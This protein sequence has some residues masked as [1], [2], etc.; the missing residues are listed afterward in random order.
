[1]AVDTPA[2]S[3]HR[4][5]A[6]TWYSMF[7]YADRLQYVLL[8]FDPLARSPPL[9]F[10]SLVQLVLQLPSQSG[11]HVL[12]GGGA[13]G[14]RKGGGDIHLRQRVLCCEEPRGEPIDI[15]DL[16]DRPPSMT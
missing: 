13:V 4:G 1:M 16:I 9:S 11:H 2:Q 14:V 8:T 5:I 3:R 10:P 15:V 7:F 6:F 12:R